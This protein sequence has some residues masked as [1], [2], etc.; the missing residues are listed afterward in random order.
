MITL[1]RIVVD[2]ENIKTNK[3]VNLFI[4]NHKNKHYKIDI[5]NGDVNIFCINE[6]T[7]DVTYDLNLFGG[8]TSFNLFNNKAQDVFINVN[9]NNENVVFNFYN[10]V[11]ANKAE[12]VHVLVTH[13]ASKTV[14]NV[15]NC[16]VTKDDGSICF[17]VTTKVLR[18]KKDCKVTQDSRI[19]SFNDNKL[20]KINPV[21]LIDEYEVEAS[22]AAFIG[23]FQPDELFYLQARGLTKEE[24]SSLLLEGCLI[25]ALDIADEEKESLKQKLVF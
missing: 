23:T 7:F 22:H 24:A 1:N 25:G 19:I 8:K 5:L 17:D 13:N 6:N 9:I 3:S 12:N 16:G 15:Y 20:N 4:N 21:L 2:N 10:G 14:S 11:V 18:G